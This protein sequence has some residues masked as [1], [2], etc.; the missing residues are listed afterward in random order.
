MQ[1]RETLKRFKWPFMAIKT[2]VTDSL[3]SIRYDQFR[4]IDFLKKLFRLV[5]QPREEPA[6]RERFRGSIEKGKI[7][8]K[9]MQAIKKIY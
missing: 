9:R 7:L 6:K 2:E 8:Q 4:T 1:K 5:G 3:Q